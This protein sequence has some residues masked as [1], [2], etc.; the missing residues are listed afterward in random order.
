MLC[1]HTVLSVQS[2]IENATFWVNEIKNGI[3]IA[4]F[5]S[6][7]SNDLKVFFKLHQTFH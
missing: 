1:V 4:L 3:G 7:E 5:R 2:Q 6:S